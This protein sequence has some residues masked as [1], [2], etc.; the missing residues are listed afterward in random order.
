MRVSA[1]PNEQRLTDEY[2]P[3][4]LR[5]T[6]RTNDKAVLLYPKTSPVKKMSLGGMLLE[7]Y[8][9]LQVEKKFHMALF[10]PNETL[11]VRF[12]GR[13]AS[14]VAVPDERSRRFNIGVEFLDMA[15]Y[16]RS[17]VGE[18]LGRIEQEIESFHSPSKSQRKETSE[19]G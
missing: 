6:V 15:A 2:R 1:I 3:S 17:R 11:P 8:D 19:Q 10:L 4:A 12:R 9:R 7:L 14:C 5:F 16:D 13:V 18:F